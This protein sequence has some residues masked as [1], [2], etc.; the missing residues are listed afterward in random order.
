MARCPERIAA[1]KQGNTL[2]LATMIGA[3]GS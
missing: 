2:D 3:Q 1:I